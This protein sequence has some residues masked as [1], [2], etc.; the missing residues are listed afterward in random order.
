MVAGRMVADMTFSPVQT[1]ALCQ[2]DVASLSDK[3][4]R[5]SIRETISIVPHRNY[6]DSAL[7]RR[8]QRQLVHCHRNPVRNPCAPLLNERVDDDPQ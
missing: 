4:A 1:A 2:Q 3:D 7:N 8:S 5:R 6:G